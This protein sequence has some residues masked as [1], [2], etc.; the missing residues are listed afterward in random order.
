MKN[1]YILLYIFIISFIINCDNEYTTCRLIELIDDSGNVFWKKNNDIKITT[2]NICP[3]II[4]IK[5]SREIEIFGQNGIIVNG[6]YEIGTL[7][8]NGS[9]ISN[10]RI[11]KLKD[12]KMSCTINCKQYEKFIFSSK[13]MRH[14]ILIEPNKSKNIINIQGDKENEQWHQFTGVIKCN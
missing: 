13:Y 3:M 14:G 5:K 11:S 2:L 8:E 4:K 9:Y 10:K 1:L 7:D 12:F 6:L